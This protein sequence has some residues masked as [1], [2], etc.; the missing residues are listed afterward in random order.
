MLRISYRKP[1]EIY[2]DKLFE[3]DIKKVYI[4]EKIDGKLSDSFV[5][6]CTEIE[7]DLYLC[8]FAENVN[9]KDLHVINYESPSTKIVFDGAVLENDKELR[10]LSPEI[11]SK[12]SFILGY[13]FVPIF[14][15]GSL[16]KEIINK[17]LNRNSAFKNTIN[18][19]LIKIV[20]KEGKIKI[21]K[22]KNVIE[23]IVIKIYENEF[24]SYKLVREEFE[25]IKRQFPREYYNH[26]KVKNRIRVYSP[27]E[28]YSYWEEYV[29]RPLRSR[30]DK[31]LYLVAYENYCHCYNK[32]TLEAC[33]KSIPKENKKPIIKNIKKLISK[34][35][36][37]ELS[38]T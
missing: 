3:K 12:I 6:S 34:Y 9:V 25:K 15:I 28:F 22:T 26:L 36:K 29:F 37:S 27:K 30:I 20:E 31:S 23:G 19:N 21:D 17:S 5:D 38:V 1:E 14:Y 18:P 16:N 4:E 10:Y 24:E 2:E 11:S 8:L 32:A 33:I 35:Y 13:F 7:K